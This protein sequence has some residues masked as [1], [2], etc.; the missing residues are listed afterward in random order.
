MHLSIK[1]SSVN[2]V[3]FENEVVQEIHQTFDSSTGFDFE[4]FM[5][6]IPKIQRFDDAKFLRNLKF[7]YNI[8]LC[9]EIL[10]KNNS[11]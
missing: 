5:N 8:N 9:L 11:H 6:F 1:K 2:S 10:K 7:I 4:K 3:I